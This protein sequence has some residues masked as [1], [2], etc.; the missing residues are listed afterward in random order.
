MAVS[1]LKKHEAVIWLPPRAIGERAF[2][3]EACLVVTHATDGRTRTIR[4]SLDAL[5]RVRQVTLVYDAR[6]VTLL[7]TRLPALSG[8]R[9][10]QALPNV[11]EENLLQ[12]AQLCAFALGPELAGGMRTVAV[13]DRAWFDFT[14]GAIERRGLRIRS[15]TAAQAAA[16]VPPGGLALIAVHDGVALC[17]PQ[18]IGWTAGADPA[19]RVEAVRSVL[20]EAL[21]ASAER[22]T[23][24]VAHLEDAGWAAAVQEA[25]GVAAVA[26][27]LR[28]LPVPHPSALDLLSARGGSGV[29]RWL[30]DI[31]WRAWRLPAA[32]LAA[33][34][35]VFLVGL[36]LHWGKLAQ[37]RDELRASLERRFRQ[38]FPDARV[39]VDPVAQMER[40]VAQ[41]RAR[42]GRSG[43]SDFTPLVGRL[44]QALGTQASDALTSIE[45]RDGRLQVKFNPALTGAASVRDAMVVSCHRAGLKL[46]FQGG[47]ATATV[48]LL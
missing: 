37:E 17:G 5:P 26:A 29:G 2:A 21:A 27:E 6:D 23:R 30:A 25:A 40:Q 43:P 20:G 10:R 9:L 31:D 11:L 32:M 14:L 34:V 24:L 15:A 4:S 46:Q 16:T 13:I 36:N 41:L 42:A 22:P 1:I 35:A 3:S 48:S 45:Y 44:A 38:T 47:G 12:D 18:G 39:V 8:A 7:A 28:T 19:G 33:G